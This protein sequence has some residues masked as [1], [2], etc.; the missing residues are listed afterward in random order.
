MG[1]THARQLREPLDHQFVQQPR[2]G[3]RRDLGEARPP[4]EEH[5]LYVNPTVREGLDALS[6][7]EGLR[8]IT[9]DLGG[10]K[11][12]SLSAAIGGAAVVALGLAYAGWSKIGAVETDFSATTKG[13]GKNEAREL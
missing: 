2:A 10:Y 6:R 4:A 12:G 5:A 13:V 1:H 11:R 3:L 7:A 8:W 9:L